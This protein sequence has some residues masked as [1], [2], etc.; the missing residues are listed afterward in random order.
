MEIKNTDS[1]LED[2][3]LE[4]NLTDGVSEDVWDRQIQEKLYVSLDNMKNEIINWVRDNTMSLAEQFKY[5]VA[6]GDYD[7]FFDEKQLI[8]G[9]FAEEASK[10]E[11]W[12]ISGA[13]LDLKLNLIKFAFSCKAIDEGDSLKGYVYVSENGKVKHAFAQNES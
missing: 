11:N 13:K 5:V 10:I 12:I 3:W 1:K 4:L 8:Q 6:F 2:I 7:R 9:F